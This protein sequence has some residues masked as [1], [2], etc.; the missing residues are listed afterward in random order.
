MLVTSAEVMVVKFSYSKTY[1]ALRRGFKKIQSMNVNLDN[2]KQGNYSLLDCNMTEI[3][4][5][6]VMQACI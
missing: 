3:T 5:N 4:G 6:L 1:E 2:L